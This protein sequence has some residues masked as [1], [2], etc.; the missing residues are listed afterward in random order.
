MT[1]EILL[2]MICNKPKVR[3][4]HTNSLALC[5]RR[6]DQHLDMNRTL[7]SVMLV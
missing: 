1:L 2:K 4:F 7:V 3:C 6:E 5:F